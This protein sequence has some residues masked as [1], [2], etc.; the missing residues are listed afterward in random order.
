MRNIEKVK[1]TVTNGNPHENHKAIITV[2][3]NKYN[4]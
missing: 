3:G 4:Q 2:K 1:T